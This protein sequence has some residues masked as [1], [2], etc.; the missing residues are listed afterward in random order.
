MNT[1]P[2]NMRTYHGIKLAKVEDQGAQLH[3]GG[4][5]WRLVYC[6]VQELQHLH[7]HLLAPLEPLR[8]QQ[9]SATRCCK[10]LHTSMGVWLRACKTTQTTNEDL[11]SAWAKM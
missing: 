9:H 7:L 6:P 3:V 2:S 11:A 10:S 1:G 8:R 4:C 5:L